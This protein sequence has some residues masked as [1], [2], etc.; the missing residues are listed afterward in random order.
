MNVHSYDLRS[1]NMET[2][3]NDSRELCMLYALTVL[4]FLPE[5]SNT[6]PTGTHTRQNTEH[7]PEQTRQAHTMQ[8]TDVRGDTAKRR[9]DTF[10]DG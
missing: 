8:G 10:G 5:A 3:R 4:A 9:G 7:R 2:E 6:A 1:F